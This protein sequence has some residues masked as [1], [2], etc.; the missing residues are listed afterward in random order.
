MKKTVAWILTAVMIPALA[1]CG[2]NPEN[3]DGAGNIQNA[4]GNAGPQGSQ[5]ERE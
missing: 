2:E 1:S 3:T 5:E 4:S